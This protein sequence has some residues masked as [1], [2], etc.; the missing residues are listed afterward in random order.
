MQLIISININKNIQMLGMTNSGY[1]NWKHDERRENNGKMFMPQPYPHHNQNINR[2]NNNNN[3]SN[4]N[5]TSTYRNGI[6]RNRN[7]NT[8]TNRNT[9]NGRRRT[10]SPRNE[11]KIDYG[12]SE[13]QAKRRRLNSN[14]QKSHIS[15]ITNTIN[16]STSITTNNPFYRPNNNSN[17]HNSDSASNITN[18]NENKNKHKNKNTNKN[19]TENVRNKNEIVQIPMKTR[20]SMNAKNDNIG[21]RAPVP[22]LIENNPKINA[23]GLLH[24]LVQCIMFQFSR[25]S[26]LFSLFYLT[27]YFFWYSRVI[28]N[29]HLY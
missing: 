7:S 19:V 13:Q 24:G 17:N 9:R 2:T 3:N 20:M 15:G 27:F 11:E 28:F 10:L 18:E 26:I 23:N 5:N 22:M 12:L 1:R 4:N 29:L 14:N 8:N 6:N 16:I 25:I 21:I